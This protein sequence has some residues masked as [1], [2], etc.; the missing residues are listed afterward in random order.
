VVALLE[1][2]GF[3]SRPH[4][5]PQHGWRD[6]LGTRGEPPDRV[7][8]VVAAS[9]RVRPTGC[10]RTSTRPSRRHPSGSWPPASSPTSARRTPA[11]PRTRAFRAPSSPHCPGRTPTP[12]GD[13]TGSRPRSAHRSG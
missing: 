7:R 11:C 9:A 13:P 6:V 2:L 3:P 5:R 4:R 10:T 1:H 8:I 12:E